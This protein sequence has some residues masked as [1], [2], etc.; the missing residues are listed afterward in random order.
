MWGLTATV[1]AKPVLF[2]SFSLLRGTLN[3]NP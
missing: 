1:G 3:C 2:L